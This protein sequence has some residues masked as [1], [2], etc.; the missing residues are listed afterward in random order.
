MVQMIDSAGDKWG[1]NRLEA[2][3]AIMGSAMEEPIK[4][5]FEE[6]V[7]AVQL[8]SLYVNICTKQGYSYE[9]IIMDCL[10]RGIGWLEEK[11]NNKRIFPNEA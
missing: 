6:D 7:I 9:R 4:L 5:W 3:E 11:E 8:P 2:V 1:L 10:T